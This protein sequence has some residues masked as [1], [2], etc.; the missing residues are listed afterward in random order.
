MSERVNVA[1]IFGESVFNDAVM[2]ERL[3]KSVYKKLKKTIVEGKELEAGIADSVAQGCGAGRN[4]LHSLVPA[5]DR[6]H[7]RKT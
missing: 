5:S 2:R 1:E 7:S 4:P 6:C 3:P